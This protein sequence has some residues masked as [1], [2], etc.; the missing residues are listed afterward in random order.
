M[1]R[2]DDT[3]RFYDLLGALA[4]SVDGPRLLRECT[5][6][7]GWPSHGVYFFFE[8]GQ[9]RQDSDEPRCV[10]V[11]TH[12]LLSA[13]AGAVDRPSPDWLGL[14]AQNE[15]VRTSGLWNVNHVDDVYDPR[16]LDV[17]AGHVTSA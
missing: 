10:R 16:F 3:D 17:L 11:G 8:P 6:R 9:T 7:S 1:S 12:A 5:G 14:W 13:R 15:R 2:R 4:K